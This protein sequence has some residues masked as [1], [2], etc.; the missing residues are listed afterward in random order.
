M[1]A[2]GG[3]A[4]RERKKSSHVVQYNV[5]VV[6]LDACAY[7]STQTLNGEVLFYM[8]IFRLVVKALIKSYLC[9]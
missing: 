7:A 2:L 6:K 3:D 8:A 9:M 1:V 5:P 4:H